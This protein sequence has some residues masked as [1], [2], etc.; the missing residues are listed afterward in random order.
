MCSWAIHEC[1]WTT[2]E[3][4]MNY[5][6]EFL[7]IIFMK[8]RLFMNQQELRLF[9]NVPDKPV[10]LQLSYQAHN[11]WLKFMKLSHGLSLTSHEQN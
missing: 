11:N 5:Q 9:H 1:S 4:F 10:T 6:P 2:N 7:S 8:L 3:T